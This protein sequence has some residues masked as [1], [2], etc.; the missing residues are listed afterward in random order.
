M[1]K[2]NNST[3]EQ[4]ALEHEQSQRLLQAVR[5]LDAHEQTLISL[6]YFLQLPER[7]VA[8]TLNVP[9][10]TVKSR[11]YRTLAHLREIITRDFPDLKPLVR[12]N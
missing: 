11:V 1:V 5:Q 12:T 10:G 2:Q 3:P 7:E 8:L 9:L 4:A 6:R